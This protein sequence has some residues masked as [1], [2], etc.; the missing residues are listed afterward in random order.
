MLVFIIGF[1]YFVSKFSDI[2]IYKTINSDARLYVT[3]VGCQMMHELHAPSQQSE[4][5]GR[6]AGINIQQN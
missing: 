1:S 6:N 3:Y 5:A 4:A 2:S